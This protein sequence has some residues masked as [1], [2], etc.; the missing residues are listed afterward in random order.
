MRI[1][2]TLSLLSM[3]FMGHQVFGVK[4]DPT[5]IVTSISSKEGVVDLE[6]RCN[7]LSKNVEPVT[8]I[9]APG[10]KQTKSDVERY[11]PLQGGGKLDEWHIIPCP[12]VV[13]NFDDILPEAFGQQE[14][15]D[16][17]HDAIVSIKTKHVLMVR[18][19]MDKKKLDGQIVIVANSRGAVT[20]LNLLGRYPKKNFYIKA[21]VLESPVDTIEA[22]KE[23][24]SILSPGYW[25]NVF[26]ST[27]VVTNPINLVEHIDKELP[28]LLVHSR[29]NQVISID[30]ARALYKALRTSGHEHV[31]LFELDFA[32]DGDY[33]TSL[34]SEVYQAV[35]H[36]FYKRYNIPHDPVLAA[37]GE[38]WL[39]RSQPSV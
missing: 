28:I 31:Y 7:D 1:L 19:T 24:K 35:V 9:F 22:M 30:S 23:F 20:A 25:S 6:A 3:I 29:D 18:E 8:F 11:L 32:Q 34:N 21:L 33:Q 13:V 39:M 27:D 14:D 12:Y 15:F 16:A 17:L 36:A 2:K 10:L 38:S 26:F 37:G 4:F 5:A